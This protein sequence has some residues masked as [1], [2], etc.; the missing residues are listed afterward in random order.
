[1]R[2]K[3]PHRSPRLSRRQ[4][5][6]RLTFCA[7]AACVAVVAG[8]VALDLYLW[9]RGETA[10]VYETGPGAAPRR[11]LYEWNDNLANSLLFRVDPELSWGLRPGARLKL[12]YLWGHGK[13]KRFDV[14][15]N[16]LGCRGKPLSKHKN[17]K[18]LRI[19][20]L[21]DS[22][23]YGQGVND[24][25]A[26]PAQLER[27]LAQALPGRRVEC[28]N[29][30]VPGYSSFQGMLLANRLLAHGP[31]ALVL[32]FST[33]DA[34]LRPRSD[35]EVHSR[36]SRFSVTVQAWLDRSMV[37]LRLRK[38]LRPSH[39]P[40]S[41]T[42]TLVPRVAPSEYVQNLTQVIEI[43]RIAGLRMVLVHIPALSGQEVVD[44]PYAQV[45]RTISLRN[46]VVLVDFRGVMAAARRDPAGLYIEA[47]YLNEAGHR[48]LAGALAEAIARPPDEDPK[49]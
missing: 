45:A 31:D 1:M 15:V 39:P 10:K 12:A 47:G 35:S 25:D 28:L 13:R 42:G 44:A 24:H 23:T 19:F 43:C 37:Y 3:P 41:R 46:E 5:R 7:A 34:T 40:A 14:T 17:P 38:A 11:G 27:Q 20:C 32:C 8:A 4:L 48:L 33:N 22:R 18:G 36:A 9:R 16:G 29:A 6:R 2:T 21:G 49:P 26:Y 30:G